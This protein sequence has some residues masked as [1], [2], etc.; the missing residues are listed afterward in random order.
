L[1]IAYELAIGT[2]RWC[3]VI[4]RNNAIDAI[5]VLGGRV[6]SIPVLRPDKTTILVDGDQ[7]VHPFFPR[8][9][10][11]LLLLQSFPRHC[12]VFELPALAIIE[13]VEE[14]LIRLCLL[15]RLVVC[16][17]IAAIAMFLVDHFQEVL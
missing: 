9:V 10:T 16:A 6:D 14:V 12:G 2:I 3:G 4:H 8:Q 17:Q 11:H 1:P 5:L 7:V 15:P 13:P